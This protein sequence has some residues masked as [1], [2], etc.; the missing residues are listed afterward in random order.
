M[1]TLPRIAF[2]VAPLVSSLVFSASHADS[3][4][5]VSAVK[6]RW[7]VTKDLKHKVEDGTPEYNVSGMACSGAESQSRNCLIID[8]E[9]TFAERVVARNR[10]LE[11]GIQWS[12]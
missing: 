10:E 7:T 5:S 6:A 12:S 4:P 3:P 1:Q 9:L 2:A 11:P 8:D